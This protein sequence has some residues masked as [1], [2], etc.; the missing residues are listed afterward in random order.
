L[1]EFRQPY[2]FSDKAMTFGLRVVLSIALILGAQSAAA[3]QAKPPAATAQ[4]KPEPM[5][6][7][8]VAL[9]L[10]IKGAVLALHQANVTGNYS[11]VRDMG[12][13]VFRE[14]FDQ[15]ALTAAFSNLRARKIDLSPALLLAPSLTKNPELNQN[16]EL[17]LV[18]SFP[19]QPLQIRFELAF[20]Q[21]D[22]MYRLA[23]IGVDAVP[24][25]ASQASAAATSIGPTPASPPQ[26]ASQQADTKG[27][28]KP[29]KPAT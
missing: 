15:A 4:A 22:G 26:P 9:T 6:I 23:G 25:P 13:P 19:T 8:I 16:G 27:E 11:V 17:V 12:T 3:Q 1:P 5:K 29:K 7:S 21:L 10:M 20:L 2:L 18:G 28:K 14:K 24:P